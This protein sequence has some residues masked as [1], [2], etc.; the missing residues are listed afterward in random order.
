M[1]FAPAFCRR[2][3]A[4]IED[5]HC[6]GAE[7]VEEYAGRGGFGMPIYVHA[8]CIRD[9]HGKLQYLLA[10]GTA[11]L[12]LMTARTNVPSCLADCAGSL[13]VE[14]VDEVD[15]TITSASSLSVQVYENGPSFCFL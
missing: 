6:P 9:E 13:S 4:L 12:D 8:K 1:H 10:T 11:A 3:T 5:R 7:W 14:L 15:T 2:M